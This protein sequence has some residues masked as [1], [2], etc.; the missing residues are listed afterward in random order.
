MEGEMGWK[1]RM[2][3]GCEEVEELSPKGQEG[4]GETPQGECKDRGGVGFLDRDGEEKKTTKKQIKHI[5]QSGE[6]D[7]VTQK[8]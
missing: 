5:L 6:K 7:N 1:G 8:M 2:N 3:K 4:E